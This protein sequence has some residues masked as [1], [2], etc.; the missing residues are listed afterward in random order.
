MDF[1]TYRRTHYFC[2][3]QIDKQINPTICVLSSFDLRVFERKSEETTCNLWP[4]PARYIGRV[5]D[6]IQ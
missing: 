6:A 5:K 3:K 4:D 2:R 1:I